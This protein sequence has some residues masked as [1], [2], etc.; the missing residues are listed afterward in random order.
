MP[1]M[2]ERFRAFIAIDLPS[3]VK[4][5]LAA[6]R[7]E[8][9]PR[10]PE[11]AVRWN[12][13]EKMHLTLRFLGDTEVAKVQ[14]IGS[15]LESIAA[16]H[17]PFQLALDALGCFPNPRRPR[18]IW[19]GLDGDVAELHQVKEMVD[20]RLAPLGWA[21]EDRAYHPHLT[22]GRVRGLEGISLPWGT[23]V[24]PLSFTASALHLYESDLRPSGPLY[25]VRHSAALTS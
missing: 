12:S 4:D 8:L 11:G 3:D 5:A 6:I 17:A 14:E 15:A 22:L 18:V 20:E 1:T 24:V 10:V 9:E 2:T 23:P 16:A 21:P 25:T 19:V 13:R 7:R